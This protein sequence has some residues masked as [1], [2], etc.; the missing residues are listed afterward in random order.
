MDTTIK[1]WM[2]KNKINV[3]TLAQILGV[4]ESYASRLWRGQRRL[5]PEKAIQFRNKFCPEIPL[6]DLLQKPVS[7]LISRTIPQDKRK[8]ANKGE[9]LKKNQQNRQKKNGG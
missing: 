2:T 5:A 3:T 6:E 8:N 9:N 1:Q 7:K 4:T